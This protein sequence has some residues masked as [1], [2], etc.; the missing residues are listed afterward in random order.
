MAIALQVKIRIHVYRGY[1][2][3]GHIVN[4]TCVFSFNIHL[5]NFRLQWGIGLALGL[6]L[7]NS[8]VICSGSIGGVCVGGVWTYN[9]HMCGRNFFDWYSNGTCIRTEIHNL[10][11]FFDVMKTEW[12][13][14][15]TFYWLNDANIWSLI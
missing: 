2:I 6:H 7:E 3:E 10:K 5:F 8:Q 9:Q 15:L 12:H 1:S 11:C 13:Q 14:K 4:I